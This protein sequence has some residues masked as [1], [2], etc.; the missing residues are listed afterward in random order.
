MESQDE[1]FRKALTLDKSATAKV[2]CRWLQ[3]P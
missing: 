3:L 1:N 2:H